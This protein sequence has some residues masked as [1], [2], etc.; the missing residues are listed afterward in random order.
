MWM[1]VTVGQKAICSFERLG[2]VTHVSFVAAYCDIL[3]LVPR[4]SITE[5]FMVRT[6]QPRCL[7]DSGRTKVQCADHSHVGSTTGRSSESNSARSLQSIESCNYVRKA[8]MACQYCGNMHDC[9][10]A[11]D[12]YS[13]RAE[14]Y[15]TAYRTPLAIS[16]Q[17]LSDEACAAVAS[18]RFHMKVTRRPDDGNSKA[19]TD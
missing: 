19:S 9:I 2:F 10:P 11:V 5:T 1:E 12:L 13:G 16:G 6:R 15:S 4:W 3:Y 17:G 8:Q 18:G 14:K 7:S